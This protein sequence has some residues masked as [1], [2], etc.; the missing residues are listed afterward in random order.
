MV[1]RATTR[2]GLP[3]SS[4]RPGSSRAGVSRA[5]I[6]AARRSAV[7]ARGC[8]AIAHRCPDFPETR[9]GSRLQP[10]ASV[11]HCGNTSSRIRTRTTSS[12]AQESPVDIDVRESGK[13]A[14]SSPLVP[15]RP[16][17][18]EVCHERQSQN[19]DSRG[20]NRARLRDRAPRL[21]P[22]RQAH[23]L[24]RRPGRRHVP[25]RGQRHPDFRAREGIRRLPHQGAVLRRLGGEPAPGRPGQDALRRGLF[26]TRVP[27]A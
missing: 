24:R 4:A 18:T 5:R 10:S 23:G 15:A 7:A 2:P 19:P 25:D 6:G 26:R 3:R 17:E 11:R 14:G 12:D 9:S 13:A 21:R 22:R 1:H 16:Q 8:E 27:R 20:C